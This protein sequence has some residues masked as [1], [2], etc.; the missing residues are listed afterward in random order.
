M[1]S[2]VRLW[3]SAPFYSRR[4][5]RLFYFFTKIR[6]DDNLLNGHAHLRPFIKNMLPQN[7]LTVNDKIRPI[8]KYSRFGLHK[9]AAEP[10]CSAAFYFI[11]AAMSYLCGHV[12]NHLVNRRLNGLIPVVS[13]LY[14]SGNRRVNMVSFALFPVVGRPFNS[15]L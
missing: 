9:K 1:R 5:R 15:L 6:T 10:F 7:N 3:L 2:P 14:V 4:F 13:N 8:S 11:Y 12:G